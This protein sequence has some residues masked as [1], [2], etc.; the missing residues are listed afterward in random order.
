MV[1]RCDRAVG[2]S[3]SQIDTEYD[4]IA[5]LCNTSWIGVKHTR[6]VLSPQNRTDPRQVMIIVLGDEKEEVHGTHRLVEAGVQGRPVDRGVVER[7]Q[8]LKRL[9][10]HCLETIQ[11]VG[12]V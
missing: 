11:Q 8:E 9:L 1:A 5:L 7:G 6:H 10:A 3:S 2:L 4:A 12:K